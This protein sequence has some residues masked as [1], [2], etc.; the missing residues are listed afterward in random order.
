MKFFGNTPLQS[1][2]TKTTIIS[3]T[4]SMGTSAIYWLARYILPNPMGIHL[5]TSSPKISAVL[6]TLNIPHAMLGTGLRVFSR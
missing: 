1:S 2:L 4:P 6:V 3:H 5:V